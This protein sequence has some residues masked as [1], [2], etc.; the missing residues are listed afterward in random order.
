MSKT[1]RTLA[2]CRVPIPIYCHHCEKRLPRSA[3][4]DVQL[5]HVVVHCPKCGLMTPF[6][7][8]D[9]A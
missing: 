9:A 4:I 7:L 2:D 8:E 5:P 1:F 3:R 6:K